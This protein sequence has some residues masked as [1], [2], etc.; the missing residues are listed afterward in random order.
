MPAPIDIKNQVFGR[1]TA[2]EKTNKRDSAGSVVWMC[3]CLCGTPH[4]VSSRMLRSG[5]VKS[6]GCAQLEYCDSGTARR[7]HRK[8]GTPIYAI[9]NSMKQRCLNPNSHAYAD[10]GGRGISV[11][12]QWMTFDNFYADM[13]DR[14]G[15]LTLDR[16]DNDG[17]YEPDNVRWAT[18]SQQAFNRRPKAASRSRLTALSLTT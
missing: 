15:E 1:L 2:V 7:R 4:H 6:C 3:K 8:A 18:R 9:W 5:Q 17:N 13:G 16:I 12:K 11:C 10:Y 14:P